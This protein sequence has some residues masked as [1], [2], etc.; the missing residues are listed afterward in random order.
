MTEQRENVESDYNQSKYVLHDMHIFFKM[1][2]N[3]RHDYLL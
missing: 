1:E 3:K 2:K